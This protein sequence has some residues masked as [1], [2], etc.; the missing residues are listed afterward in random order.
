ML[1]VDGLHG[2]L[3]SC[4]G[5]SIFYFY[6][7]IPEISLKAISN[8][9]GAVLV[10]GGGIAGIQASLDL[11][12]SGYKVYLVEKSPAIG[13]TMAQ[14]D[15][16]FP[17]ND[18]SMCIMSPKLVDAGRHRNIEILT[19]A[20]VEKVEGGPGDFKV[21][22]HKK[23]RY[24]SVEACKAC[25]ECVEVCPIRIPND[26][27]R[28]LV[29]RAAIYQLFAQAMPSA[30][31]ITKKGTPPCRASCPIH[32]NAQGY[33]ALI[34][35]GKF[36]E[37]LALERE[38]NPFPGIT[39][40]ICT[41]PC[42]EVCR[43]KEVERAVAIDGLKRFVSDYEKED[44]TN[45]SVPE[46]NGKKVALVGSGP[47]GLLAAYDL[48]KM[49]YGATIFEA[50]PVAGGMLA[51]GIPEYRLPRSVLNKEIDYLLRIGVEIKFNTPIGK[52]LSLQD[53]KVQGYDAIFIATGAHQS[54]KLGLPG[55]NALGVIHAVDFL[56]KVALGEPAKI[57]DRVIVVGGGNAAIDAA[58]TAFRLGSREVT[59]AY[60]RT[61]H[62]MPAREEEIEEAE[63][64][65]IKIEY[66]TAPTRLILENGEIRGMACLRMALGEPDESGRPRP[67]PISGSEFLIEADTI[68][69]AIS[70]SPDLSF[71]TEKDGLKT[72]RWGT[73]EADPVTLETSVKGIFAGGDA[74]TGPQT[75]IDAMAAGRKAAISIDRYLRGEDLRKGREGEGA[76]KD[77]VLID[78]EGYEHRERAPMIALPLEKRRSF[79]EVNRG[80][81]EEDAVSEAKRCLQCG[82]CSECM[83]CIKACKAKAIDHQMEDE[84]LEI[85]V[86]SIVLSP[87]FQEFDTTIFSNYG[88][89]VFPNV[90]TSIEFERI[91]SAS[92][93]F[94]GHLVRLSDHQVPKR[95]A[96]IQCVGSRDIHHAKNAYCSSVCCT[97]AIK[98][99]IVAQE[100]CPTPLETTIFII[101]LRTFGKGFERYYERAKRD[102]GVLFVR[103]RVTTLYQERDGDLTI[104]YFD[105]DQIKEERFSMV[106]L[107]VGL[108]QPEETKALAGRIGL[109]LNEY[110]FCDTR[111]FSTVTTS[112]PGIFSAGVFSGPKDI[113]ETVME[114]SAAATEASSLI[115]ASRHHLTTEKKYPPESEVEGERP[116]IGVF[117]C[118]C[119][120]NIGGVLDVPS[121]S[122]Y[123]RSLPNVVFADDPLFAC[124]Q[125]NQQKIQEIVRE[126]RLNRLI[127]AACSP[128]THEPLFQETLREAGLNRYL[129]EMANIRDQCSWVHMN[130]PEAGTLKA[131]DLIRSAVA[132]ARH[133]NPLKQISFEVDR[134]GLVIG[135]GISGMVS[136]LHLA[137]QGFPV[138]LVERTSELGGIA[139]RHHHTLEGKDVQAFLQGL[140]AEMSQEPLIHVHKETDV[141]EVSGYV[142]NFKTKMRDRSSGDIVEIKHGVVILATGGE[143]YKPD[144]Y[145]YGK[146]SRV[147]TLLDLKDEIAKGSPSIV[148]SKNLVLIQCVGSRESERL[149]CS[150]VCCSGSI[151]T[152]LQ[153]K[154]INPEMNIYIL[155]RDIRTYGFKELYYQEARDKGIIFIRYEVDDKPVVEAIKEGDQDILRVSLKDPLL[156]EPVF[157]DADVVG[158]AT[159]I[160]P[161]SGR[162]ELAQFFKVPLNEDGFFMEAHIKLRPVEFLA[163]GVFVCGLAHNPKFIEESVVQAG[164]AVSKALTILTKERIEV[165]G[166]VSWVEQEECTGCGICQEVCPCKAIEIDH[167]KMVA[168]VN[169]ALCRGC[170]VCAASCHSGSIDL[171]GFTKA[172]VIAQINEL[173][174]C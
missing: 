170:G 60:R 143:V 137:R 42:E 14:L 56:R 11:A 166:V 119:G 67:V 84:R 70:Q 115:A 129:F 105:E 8:E 98:E 21:L 104:R 140:I 163:E 148:G 145:L 114:A 10:V 142:G 50:L 31:S 40:R 44:K 5:S 156:G 75:Y 167:K 72:T 37:A 168:V 33:I 171:K 134:T 173:A 32:V 52:N 153:L 125:D 124:S 68:I 25:G 96:W 97:Y 89:G 91:L 155:Y 64:E 126:L 6:Y 103:A 116:R 169:E 107:S 3:K 154:E 15:K 92:G 93:P 141:Q 77:Y 45:L 65:G 79:D 16:T 172:E 128:R 90:V 59:I 157:I 139:R 36:E 17:T 49:G 73:I 136:A 81:R 162:E 111:D 18:C 12:E 149:Y 133:I 152:A 106:V 132:K 46:E 27:E 135:G 100:H 62:E 63:R 130:Q 85:R 83:E 39:G 117:V 76:Q 161:A 108:R 158:L 110:G 51:V 74:V 41:H 69:L 20:R 147:F 30:Y 123:A 131:K 127:V 120:I 87:G 109:K 86:G 4:H 13:G 159:A 164:A 122:E 35:V 80:L 24:V 95:I 22:V 19:N 112:K 43:R 138:H 71:I 101:D 23:A 48:R 29:T 1:I 28:G 150:R 94:Q 99:A 102:Y 58:R 38:K 7:W 26:F 121:L 47:A 61:R 160:V 9:I 146:D 34:S 66:L 78:I 53:L 54:R 55:E 88:H 165:G 82:G 118:H 113:P 57:G 144:E 2:G 151:K 174:L